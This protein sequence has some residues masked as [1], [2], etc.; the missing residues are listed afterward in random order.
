MRCATMSD[1]GTLVG[2]ACSIEDVSDRR[3]TEEALRQSEE[4]LHLALESSHLALFDW[5]IPSGALF[6]SREWN[7]LTGGA[8][9]PPGTARRLNDLIH[10][11]DRERLRHAFIGAF[12]TNKPV[13]R[14]E[15]RIETRSGQWK[16][17]YC[18]GRVTQRDAL[19]RAVRLAG[20]VTAD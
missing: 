11:E 5:H 2:Y 17:L 4:H 9:S 10:P 16:R 12:K 20:T 7:A 15:F 19:G 13:S 18:S 3:V 6:L 14:V 8:Q 1:A